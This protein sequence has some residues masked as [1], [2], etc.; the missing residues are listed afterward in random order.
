MGVEVLEAL[1][2]SFLD[3]I[4]IG[5]L[6]F[7]THKAQNI[8]CK[9]RV[10]DKNRADKVGTHKVMAAV[11]LALGIKVHTHTLFY[12]FDKGIVVVLRVAGGKLGLEAHYLF[13]LK[14]T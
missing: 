13:T 10:Q 2:V 3:N 8:S 12:S 11:S 1:F 14:H 5:K 7:G 9:V 4:I 6:G